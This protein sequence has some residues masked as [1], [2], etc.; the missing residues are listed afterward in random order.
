MFKKSIV[1][2]IPWVITA[3]ALYIAFR[4]IDWRTLLAYLGAASPAWLVLALSVT[5]LSYL[6]RSRRWQLFFPRPALDFGNSTRALIL[7]FFMNNVLP[8]RTGELVRAHL[9]SKLSGET[10]TLV[11]ATIASERLADGLTI[12]AFFLIFALG[13]GSYKISQGLEMVAFLFLVAAFIVFVALSQ[14]EALFGIAQ[15]FERRFNTRA[16]RYTVNRFQVF[17]DGLKPLYSPKRFPRLLLWSVAIWMV[18]LC[19]YMAVSTAYSQQLPVNHIV[20]FLVAVNFGALIPAAPGGFGVIEAIASAVLVSI[21]IERELALAM[22]ISQH[23]I[24]YI[25]VGVPGAFLTFNWRSRLQK[26]EEFSSR[27]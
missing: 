19:V 21:G 2:L 15:R 14:R 26:I 5:A 7:G 24:Q 11:L 13:I 22:V 18:E 10:R 9:G 1:R 23:L 20:L 3:L 17:I 12:S 8:A 4:G 27:Q 16:S 25:V 6:M